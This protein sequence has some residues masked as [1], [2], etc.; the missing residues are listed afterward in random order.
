MKKEWGPAA[1]ANDRVGKGGRD[2]WTK[3]ATLPSIP[4]LDEPV[5]VDDDAE[6]KAFHHICEEFEAL[7]I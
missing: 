7:E 3:D 1:A 4:R 6:D 5:L 2:V